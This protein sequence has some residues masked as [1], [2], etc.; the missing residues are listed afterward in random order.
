MDRVRP[1]WVDYFLKMA[2][3]ASERSEDPH[4]QH[5]A[6]IVDNHN[7]QIIGTGY[8]GLIQGLTLDLLQNVCNINVADR[9]I[10]RLFMIHAEENAIL[11]CS[12]HPSRLKEGASIYVTGKPC[13]NCLQRIIRFKIKDIYCKNQVGS[14]TDTEETERIRLEIVSKTGTNLHYI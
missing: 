14:I 12:V 5:G 11:S 13:L 1:S 7:Q 8:N 9:N 2:K 3:D 4:I 6:I 10:K